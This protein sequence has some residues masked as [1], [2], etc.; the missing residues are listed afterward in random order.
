MARGETL[1]PKGD[2]SAPQA[3]L[4]H[5]EMPGLDRVVFKPPVMSAAFFT[6]PYVGRLAP[7]P[8]GRLHLG[9]AHTFALAAA[10]A[11]AAGGRLLMRMDDLD[12]ARC[13]PEFAEAAL[14]DLAWLGLRWEEP[15]VVQSRRLDRYRAALIRLRVAG[16]VYACYRSR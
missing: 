14:A 5:G 15:V 12:G 11:R 16:L 2:E 9:H 10:R 4:A 8:T 6:R 1:H 13:R 3:P 7:S